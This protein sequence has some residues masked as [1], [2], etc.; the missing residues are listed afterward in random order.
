MKGKK[1]HFQYREKYIRF[2]GGSYSLRNSP[3]Y[4][5]VF[6]LKH[7]QRLCLP[8][9]EFRSYI[10]MSYRQIF[11]VPVYGT[12]RKDDSDASDCAQRR[13]KL[14]VGLYSTEIANLIV[15]YYTVLR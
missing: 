3:K 15:D 9:P 5:G 7:L 12:W 13:S 6:P 11:S 10:E 2:R 1:A 4:E 8:S 14:T